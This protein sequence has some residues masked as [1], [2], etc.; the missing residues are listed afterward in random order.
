MIS[1]L[2]YWI[3][4]SSLTFSTIRASSHTDFGISSFAH[5]WYWQNSSSRSYSFLL[6]ENSWNTFGNDSII[7]STLSK[8]LEER[9]SKLINLE[10]LITLSSNG[11]HL[12][13][14]L[15]AVEKYDL[16]ASK[17]LPTVCYDTSPSANNF[18]IVDFVTNP[19]PRSKSSFWF[20]E[21]TWRLEKISFFFKILWCILRL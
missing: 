13:Q 19:I 14:Y 3:A 5:C 11:S 16:T 6:S 7:A 8:W 2:W 20:F 17:N 12:R 18:L 10:F 1:I 15:N 9:L 4:S 21:W